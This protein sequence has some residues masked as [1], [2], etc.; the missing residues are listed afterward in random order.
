MLKL[1]QLKTIL[2]QMFRNGHRKEFVQDLYR[3]IVKSNETDLRAMNPNFI[4]LRIG[5]SHYQML[6]LAVDGVLSGLFEMQWDINCPRCGN[7]LI[8]CLQRLPIMPVE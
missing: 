6:N 3:F 7:I 4:A 1:P 2:T 5:I 8:C